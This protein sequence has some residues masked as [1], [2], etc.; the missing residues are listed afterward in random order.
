MWGYVSAK[1]GA[2]RE[3]ELKRD[4]WKDVLT[5]GAR[6]KRFNDTYQSAWDVIDI[7]A[8]EGL[9]TVPILPGEIFYPRLSP[10]RIFNL[11]IFR[12]QAKKLEDESH[13]TIGQLSGM[14]ISQ[15]DRVIV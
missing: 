4:L 9:G 14:K 12:K 5:D 10:G 7:V 6:T 13:R 1:E 3:E 8:D 11:N 15:H 2:H